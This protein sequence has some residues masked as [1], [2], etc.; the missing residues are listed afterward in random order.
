MRNIPQQT[1]RDFSKLVGVPYSEM[2]C[3]DI[4]VVFYKDV[5]NMDLGNIYSGPT[6][7]R[8]V[9]KELIFTNMGGFEKVDSPQFGDIIIL[10][11]FG[12][13]SHIS[14]YIGNGRMLHTSSSSGSVIDFVSRWEKIIVGFYRVKR[15]E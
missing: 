10:K 1:T 9:T 14:I 12:I 2:N 7:P 11:I 4:A 6:P 3:W 13:E 5:L 8:D 15:K